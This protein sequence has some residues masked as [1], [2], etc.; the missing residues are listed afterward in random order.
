[1]HLIY[2]NDN[3]TYNIKFYI[4]KLHIN[5]NDNISFEMDIED[6][7]TEEAIDSIDLYVGTKKRLKNVIKELQKSGIIE[8]KGEH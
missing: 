8:I 6:L 2:N 7:V 5:C 3:D 4:E 1:M